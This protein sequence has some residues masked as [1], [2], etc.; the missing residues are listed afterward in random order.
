MPLRENIPSRRKALTGL[1]SLVFTALA[2]SQ[3]FAQT[4]VDTELVL[5]V[6]VS[7]GVTTTR[8]ND[9]MTAFGDAMTSSTILDAI[10]SGRTGSIAASVMFWSS[11]NRQAVGV[12]WMQISDLTSATNF[13]AQ[14]AAAARPFTGGSALAPALSAATN[15]FGTET[16]GPENGFLSSS[17]IISL[18]TNGNNPPAQPGPSTIQ[19]ARDAALASGVDLIDVRLQAAARQNQAR[20]DYYNTNVIGSTIDGVEATTVVSNSRAAFRASLSGSLLTQIN[21]GAQASLTVVPEPSIPLLTGLAA[22]AF[23]LRRRR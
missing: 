2:T 12:P 16:G 19:A 4:E 22:L 23:G 20:L 14:L 17:Q 8:F 18:T 5:L 10:Q 7:N 3:M 6:N 11:A 1:R 9:I 15:H 13:A 21:A